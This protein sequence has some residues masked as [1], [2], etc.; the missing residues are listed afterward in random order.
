MKSIVLAILLAAPCYAD[1]MTI[2]GPFVGLNNTDSSITLLEG[3]AQD[4]LNVESSQDAL[5]LNKRKGYALL[6][7][8][9]VATS[10]VT[11]SIFFKTAAGESIKLYGYDTKVIKSVNGGLFSVVY[12][13]APVG[14]HWSFCASNGKAY[15]FNSSTFSFT[16]FSYDGDSL[17]YYPSMPKAS[18]CTTTADRM[19]LAGTTDFPSRIYFSRSGDFSDFVVGIDPEDPGFEEIGLPGEKITNIFATQ[20]EWLAYKS[21]SMTSIQ[22]TNQYDLLPSVV[23]EKIGMIEPRAIVQH[24]GAVYFKSSDGKFYAYAAGTLTEISRKIDGI[25]AGITRDSVNSAEYTTKAQFDSGTYYASTGNVTAGSVEPY[26][27]GFTDTTDADFTDGAVDNINIDGDSISL[28]P[29]LVFDN[30]GVESGNTSGWTVIGG[31]FDVVN[32][33]DYAAGFS[34][35]FGTYCFAGEAREN[36]GGAFVWISTNT[37]AKA[38]FPVYSIPVTTFKT[39]N[40]YTIDISTQSDVIY[41]FH[42]AN[43]RLSNNTIRSGPFLKGDGVVKVAS[44][45]WGSSPP[46]GDGYAGFFDVSIPVQSSGSFSSGVKVI[47]SPSPRIMTLVSNSSVPANTQ[48]D[49][50]IRSS[51]SSTG[52]FTGWEPTTNYLL[53]ADTTNQYWQYKNVFYNLGTYYP[54]TIYSIGLIAKTTG[55]WETPEVS[56]GGMNSWGIFNADTTTDGLASWNYAIYTSTYAGGTALAAPEALTDGAVITASTGTYSKILATNSFYAATETVRLD[57]LSYSWS[58]SPDKLANAFEYKG[59]IYFGVP[60]NN[61]LSNNRLLKFD[62]TTGGWNVFDIAE[63]SP[64]SIDEYVYFGSPTSGN[65]YQYPIGDS[66]AGTAINSYWKSKNYIGTNPYVEKKFLKMSIIVGSDYGSNLDVTYTMDTSTSTTYSIS[67]TSSTAEF[68]RNNRALPFGD[69]GAFF[70]LQV[71]NN[72]ANHPWSFYGA[73]IEYENEPWRVIPQD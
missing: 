34:I 48:I 65:I 39:T 73:N 23:S 11:G 51:S 16:P 17:T 3:E 28:S 22:G 13:T 14:S 21:N 70:N 18:L 50:F 19:L 1:D 12:D 6:Q 43:S 2:A 61:S 4:T 33:T 47:S 54:P 72:A 49:Y 7:A 71:G 62:V 9:D 5:A 53:I 30:M 38:N 24:E 45:H 15:A 35:E 68:V 57:N 46:G 10:P 69:T 37:D 20:S 63:N 27:Y 42:F 25:V 8:L 59:D 56:M 52:P 64:L 44:Y 58:R 41:Y 60:Y 26:D 66:D 40:Y 67:L 29:M 36:P 55:Y 31:V 32:T